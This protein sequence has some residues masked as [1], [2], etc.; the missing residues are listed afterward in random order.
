MNYF[1]VIAHPEGRLELAPVPTQELSELVKQ[2]VRQVLLEYQ[3]QK[4]ATEEELLK[5]PQVAALLGVSKQTIYEW[6]RQGKLPAH[7]IGRRVFFKKSEVVAALSAQ[8]RQ[9]LRSRV[10]RRG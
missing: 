7:K 5:L 6:K 2:A 9:P 10:N 3:D 4:G 1:R 8:S